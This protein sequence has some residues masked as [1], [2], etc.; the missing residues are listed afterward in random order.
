ME[1]PMSENHPQSEQN[2]APAQGQMYIPPQYYQAP[3]DEID[4]RELFGVLW[5]GKWWII[6]ITALFAIASI[7]YALSLPNEYKATAI[8]APASESGGG[9]LGAMAGQ[10]GGL[11]GLAGISLGSSETT[12]TVI[13]ME[14]MKTWGFID[15]FIKKHELQ[16]AIFAAKGWNQSK[17]ELIIDDEL[18]DVDQKK[19]IR[20]APKGKTVEPTSWEL[21]EEFRERLSVSQDKDSG[22]INI[23]FMHYSPEYA[24]RITQWLIEDVNALLKERALTDATKNISYLEEQIK[25]TPLSDMQNIFYSLIEEQTKTKML[26]DVGNEYVFKEISAAQVPEE[27]SEPKRALICILGVFL[28]LIFAM[29]VVLITRSKKL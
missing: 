26:A 7:F 28:G 24:Q 15:D 12:D 1:S 8:V 6:G 14:V 13:A 17:N 4:L 2:T 16:V 19:W 21:Y 18:Y 29:L 23:G 10:L 27:K 25:R 3:E 5:K 11:A 22:L 20:E 9:G